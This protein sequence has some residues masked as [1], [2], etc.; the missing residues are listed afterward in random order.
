MLK[1]VTAVMSLAACL[2]VLLTQQE[3]GFM[4]GIS[5]RSLPDTAIRPF[6]ELEMYASVAENVT[7]RGLEGTRRTCSGRVERE[8]IKNTA[9]AHNGLSPFL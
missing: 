5:S 7:L 9:K 8:M 4:M 2:L 1:N 6:N 3:P